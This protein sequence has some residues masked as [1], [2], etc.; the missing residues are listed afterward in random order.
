MFSIKEILSPSRQNG[1]QR[2]GF[3]SSLAIAALIILFHFPFEG[4]DIE[5]RVVT[6]YASSNCHIAT[7]DELNKMTEAKLQEEARKQSLCSEESEMHL[8]P[9]SEWRSQAPIVEW[10]GSLAHAIAALCFVLV[11]GATWLWVFRT[12]DGRINSV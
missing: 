9:F 7:L 10:F 3:F 12:N 2:V 1:T 6:R 5:H 11:L 8:R 4:Y